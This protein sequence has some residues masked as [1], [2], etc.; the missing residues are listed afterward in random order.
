[1]PPNSPWPMTASSATTANQRSQRR[2]SQRQATRTKAIVVGP[3]TEAPN[4]RW[5]CS[6][7]SSQGPVIQ[8]CQG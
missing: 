5:P 3:V 4:S 8:V 2:S 6:M 1:M 7:N